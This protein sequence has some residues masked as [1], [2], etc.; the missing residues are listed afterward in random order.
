M[1]VFLR[2]WLGF[3]WNPFLSGPSRSGRVWVV[4]DDDDPTLLTG[5]KYFRILVLPVAMLYG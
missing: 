5:L 2:G 3:S 1:Y 4:E